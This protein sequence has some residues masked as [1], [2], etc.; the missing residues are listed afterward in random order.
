M[1]ENSSDEDFKDAEDENVEVHEGEEGEEEAEAKE[2][3]AIKKRINLKV[4][5]FVSEAQRQHG[6]RH[7][8]YERYRRY[9]SRRLARTRK[10]LNFTSGKKGYT[11][12]KV[13]AE[14]VLEEK[15]LYIPL[16]QAERAWAYHMQ[17]KEES[18]MDDRKKFHA[19]QRIKKAREH[20]KELK[21]V[22]EDE[23]CAC[24]ERT[25]IEVTAYLELMN[26]TCS[27]EL[28]QWSQAAEQLS[29]AK[30]IYE[31]LSEACSE[32]HKVLYLQRVDEIIANLRY[33]NFMLGES[34]VDLVNMRKDPARSA[35]MNML[36]EK[37]E[38][39]VL[40]QQKDS[41]PQSSSEISWC[42]RTVSVTNEN[43]K[44]FMLRA[45]EH[46]KELTSDL[47]YDTAMG[48]FDQLYGDYNDAASMASSD[49]Q[50]AKTS[51]SQNEASDLE[52]LCAYLSFKRLEKSIERTQRMIEEAK[53][54]LSLGDENAKPDDLVR[55]YAILA[56][57]LEETREL[58]PLKG[59]ES[60]QNFASGRAW[61]CRA[62]RCFF[63]AESHLRAGRLP[64]ADLL[65]D[66]SLEEV[67]KAQ[68]ELAESSE[69]TSLINQDVQS[70][71]TKIR[72]RKCVIQARAFETSQAESLS[73]EKANIKTASLVQQL[74]QFD[75]GYATN[76]QKS[77][78][79]EFP[80]EFEPV[81]CKPLF[82]DLA[83]NH[84]KFP[85]LAERV[86]KIQAEQASAMG[87]V[88]GM[89]SGISKWFG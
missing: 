68:H 74:D 17:L 72:G 67:R 75:A 22:V 29:N 7:E 45:K 12:K 52:F 85:S 57:N 71:Q 40:E 55:L 18:K 79:V 15:Y 64:Q 37:L 48:L 16:V 87:A 60:W 25:K 23:T 41:E 83:G 38:R 54:K 26:A 31:K 63:I 14:K 82:F 39:A 76:L 81:P 35:T 24:D 4:L 9:C 8:D 47:E 43:I 66:R 19:L 56:Q 33:C 58:G 59:D 20:A 89:F 61:A 50:T 34:D 42:N 51:G 5:V 84:I 10:G 2:D 49:L 11:K 69:N 86:E 62:Q 21:N 77:N 32:A 80:P 65:L 1:A 46:E 3:K 70:L 73:T 53:R 30:L 78:L 6:L 13:T 44:M 36:V 88:A 27:I 28:L